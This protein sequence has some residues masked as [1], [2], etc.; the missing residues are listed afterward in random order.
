MNGA[1]RRY[2]KLLFCSCLF[3]CLAYATGGNS[4]QG[5][6]NQQYLQANSVEGVL[7]GCCEF[8]NW[9]PGSGLFGRNEN[10]HRLENGGAICGLLF[11]HCGSRCAPFNKARNDFKRVCSMGIYKAGQQRAGSTAYATRAGLSSRL[12]TAKPATG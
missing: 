10:G 9:I 1:P 6:G 11:F 3:I 8:W 7:P 5:K 2:T 4:K 12:F